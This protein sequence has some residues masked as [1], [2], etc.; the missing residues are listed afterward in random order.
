MTG[1][2]R[3]D[4]LPHEVT[5]VSEKWAGGWSRLGKEGYLDDGGG[6]RK[7]NFKDLASCN[8]QPAGGDWLVVALA[9]SFNLFSGSAPLGSGRVFGVMTSEVIIDQIW[10]FG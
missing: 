7:R 10:L 6:S 2:T 3:T 4:S 1:P 8:G 9:A 5:I